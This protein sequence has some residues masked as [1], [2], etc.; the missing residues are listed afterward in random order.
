MRSRP[1]AAG[2]ERTA[3]E[4]GDRCLTI[5]DSR[6]SHLDTSP[7]QGRNGTVI[8]GLDARCEGADPK[9]KVLLAA[10]E[11][12][13][14]RVLSALTAGG[15]DVAAVLTTVPENGAAPSPIFK[16]ATKSG[17]EA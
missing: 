8:Y 15:H 16:S 1:R 10:E 2:S 4:T 5:G 12:A 3:A 17:Y 9:V 13:G 6:L 11:G 14:L 7:D